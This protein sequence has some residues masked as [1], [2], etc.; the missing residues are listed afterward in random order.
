[1]S[2]PKKSAS[3]LIFFNEQKIGKIW[4]IFGIQNWLWKKEFCY[5]WQCLLNWSQKLKKKD[6]GIL[7]GFEQKG[8]TCKMCKSVR[9]KCCHTKGHL[10][11]FNHFIEIRTTVSL[12]ISYR[13][14]VVLLKFSNKNT[15][16]PHKIDKLMVVL[17]SIK[18]LNKERRPLPNFWQIHSPLYKKNT[19]S[20][21]ITIVPK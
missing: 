20:T 15:F 17:M 5:F 4:T 11:L 10:F 16:F 3:K 19:F 14:N 13:K 7:F 8:W 9:Q 6:M 18:W 2:K 12:S 21:Q 1:M